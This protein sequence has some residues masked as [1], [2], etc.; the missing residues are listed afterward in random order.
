MKYNTKIVTAY[1]E[2]C[3]LPTPI[4]EYKFHKDRKWK[5]DIAFPAER[6]A[7]EV[8]GGLFVRGRHTQGAALLKEYEKLNELAQMGW[9]IIYV[10]PKDVTLQSTVD[11]IRRAMVWR[12]ELQDSMK[13]V[14]VDAV[15]FLAGMY[16]GLS[17]RIP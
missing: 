6:V 14:D 8:Q 3:G 5:L 4:F 9:R 10:Q 13:G 15:M 7:V 16:Q 2:Q 12:F 11:M 1:Y 17:C